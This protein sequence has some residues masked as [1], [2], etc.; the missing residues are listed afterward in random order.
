MRG[1]PACRIRFRRSDE[2]G[3]PQLAEIALQFVHGEVRINWDAD[4][5]R[6][7]RN[8]GQ[9]IIDAPRQHHR[10][11]IGLGDA[12]PAQL[13]DSIPRARGKLGIGRATAPGSK[14]R[15]PIGRGTGIKVENIPDARKGL[16]ARK[17]LASGTAGRSLR[18]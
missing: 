3:K 14:H 15:S 4:G 16:G 18:R 6:C 7:H 11:A 1:G 5:R 17:G 10:H 9:R 13:V 12:E 8:K 2:G